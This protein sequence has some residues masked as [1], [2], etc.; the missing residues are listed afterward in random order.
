MI[1]VQ[2]GSKYHC[3]VKCLHPREHFLT[4]V[5][6]PSSAGVPIFIRVYS[7][8]DLV[9]QEVSNPRE[10]AAF[11]DQ[12]SEMDALDRNHLFQAACVFLGN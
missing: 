7:D 5:I 11:L 4:V 6:E 3:T 2:I 12:F 10:V 9:G 8:H 1:N